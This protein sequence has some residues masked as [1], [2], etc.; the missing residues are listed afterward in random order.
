MSVHYEEKRRCIY[1][2]KQEKQKRA[3][4]AEFKRV[5]IWIT[6]HSAVSGVR[7]EDILF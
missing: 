6:S 1:H 2:S 4:E 5:L 3:C 7:L